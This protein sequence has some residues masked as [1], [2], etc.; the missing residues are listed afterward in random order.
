MPKMSIGQTAVTK[1]QRGPNIMYYHWASQII[2]ITEWLNNNANS[3]FHDLENIRCEPVLAD[4]P[5]INNTISLT[6]RDWVIRGSR[7]RSCFPKLR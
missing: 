2:Y 1:G 6:Y 3:T 5:F 7:E 4:I